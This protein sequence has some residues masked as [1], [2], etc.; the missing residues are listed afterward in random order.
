MS[1]EP[2]SSNSAEPSP[3]TLLAHLYSLNLKELEQISKRAAEA[4]Q[5]W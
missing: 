4:V 5:R 3:V 1:I 2:L